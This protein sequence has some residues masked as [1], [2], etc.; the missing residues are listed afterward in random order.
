MLM[1]KGSLQ[2]GQVPQLA[3]NF[4]LMPVDFLARFIA[5][6]ASRYQP[7]HAV[8]NLHNPQPL[9]WE[10]YVASFREAGREFRMVSVADWQRQL[11]RV[12]RD[13]ALFG[14]LGFYLNGFE[15][16]IGDISLIGHANAEA[17][18]RRM[19]ADYPPKD[20]ALLRKGCQYLKDIRF[21]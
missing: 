20:P 6:H 2:L 15:E 18:V 7:A 14:V 9:S 5:F 13:N 17:G 3:M 16:D 21:I 12:D 1:L 11:G 4:D 10:A 19:G 8:F